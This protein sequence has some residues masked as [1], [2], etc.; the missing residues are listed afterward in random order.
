MVFYVFCFVMQFNSSAGKP[1]ADYSCCR[2]AVPK[3]LTVRV[4]RCPACG[5]ILNRTKTQQLTF[6]KDLP[7]RP[8]EVTPGERRLS[9]A[10]TG[11]GSPVACGRVVHCSPICLSALFIPILQKG[12]F[13]TSSSRYSIPLKSMGNPSKS[14]PNCSFISFSTRKALK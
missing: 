5:I 9:Q 14:T 7:R 4:H 3:T 1:P 12:V 6:C 13:C 10:L 11:S 2:T 8:R